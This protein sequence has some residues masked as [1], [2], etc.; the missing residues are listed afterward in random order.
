MNRRLEEAA[1]VG[2]NVA[3]TLRRL[4]GQELFLLKA[5]NVIVLTTPM[6]QPSVA[7]SL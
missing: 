7:C 1:E 3:H 2:D 6:K 4:E 5:E